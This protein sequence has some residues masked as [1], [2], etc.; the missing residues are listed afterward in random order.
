MCVCVCV[1]ACVSLCLAANPLQHLESMKAIN[2]L[3]GQA[4]ALNNMARTYEYMSNLSKAAESL[5]AVS[6]I[7]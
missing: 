3:V 5:E 1:C 7:H 2:S 6:G 4:V